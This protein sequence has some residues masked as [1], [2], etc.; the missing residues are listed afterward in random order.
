MEARQGHLN[1][2][3]DGQKEH[4]GVDQRPAAVLKLPRRD[5]GG[6]R[7]VHDGR[8]VHQD[9]NAKVRPAG[10]DVVFANGEHQPG[11][12]GQ[13]KE[14]QVAPLAA[15]GRPEPEVHHLFSVHDVH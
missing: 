5:D 8:K 12:D 2:G 11:R 14:Q 6:R 7:K 13:G 4:Q 1:D 3:L 15:H 10:I 9:V